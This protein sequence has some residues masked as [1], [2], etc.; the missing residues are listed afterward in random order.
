MA[1]ITNRVI[2]SRTIH[3]G[4]EITFADI[5]VENVI[6]GDRYVPMWEVWIHG[7]IGNSVTGRLYFRDV[8]RARNVY[9][10]LCKH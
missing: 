10:F 6:G 7:S 3:M 2:R 9:N 4:S 8:E 1:R 5:T